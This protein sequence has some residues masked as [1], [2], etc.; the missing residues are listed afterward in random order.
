ML[1]SSLLHLNFLFNPVLN[2]NWRMRRHPTSCKRLKKTWHT[3]TTSLFL[4]TSPLNPKKRLIWQYFN[5]W[6]WIEHMTTNFYLYPQFPVISWHPVWSSASI[7]QGVFNKVA[8]ECMYYMYGAF[9]SL[10]DIVTMNWC[11]IKKDKIVIL[12]ST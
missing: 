10:T 11:S 2:A 8:S 3:H 6:T 9:W 12:C 7:A 1:L 5:S 4:I